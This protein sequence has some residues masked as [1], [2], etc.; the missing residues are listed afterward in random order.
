MTNRIGGGPEI[1]AIGG[2]KGGTGKSFIT[3]NI[4]TSLALKGIKTVLVDADFGGP[5]LHSLLGVP[6]S[7]KSLT[8]FFTGQSGLDDLIINCGV[9]DMGLIVGPIRSFQPDNVKYVQKIKLFNHIRKLKVDVV[10]IDL[11]SGTHFN[12]VDTFLLADKKIVVT[13]P[14]ITAMEN[15]YSFLKNSFYRKLMRAFAENK[16]KH[17]IEKAMKDRQENELANMRQ[18]IVYLKGVSSEVKRI[19]DEEL[20]NYRVNIIVNQARTG[21]DIE[22]GNSIRSICVKY[23]GFKA[24]C[25]GYVEQD[26]TIPLAINKQQ[27]YLQIYPKSR[28]AGKIE[29]IVDNLL[30]DR[31]MRVLL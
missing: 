22:L 26:E 11:G 20:S 10:I 28:C 6:N 12:I 1:W 5:N 4:A 7:D 14:H 16:I 15:M 24:R 25:V 27:P 17:I 8:D 23:F 31:Q 19:V 13:L 29:K 30:N 3:C 9:A 18:L 21:K 2:G